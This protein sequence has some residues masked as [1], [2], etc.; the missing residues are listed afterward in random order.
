MQRLRDKDGQEC[1]AVIHLRNVRYAPV[2]IKPGGDSLIG[3]GAESLKKLAAG[4]DTDRMKAPSF[5]MV[6]TGIGDYAC[7]RSDG[8]FVVPAGCLKD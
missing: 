2:E 6:L 4:I 7:R 8:V 5:L 3:E 1:D